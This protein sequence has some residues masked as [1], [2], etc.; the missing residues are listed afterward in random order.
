MGLNVLGL[1]ETPAR[2][3]S[4]EAEKD[5]T[6]MADINRAVYDDRHYLVGIALLNLGE[7][8]IQ[9]KDLRA[10]RA[11]RY[12]EALSRFIE[13][14]PAGP[15][16]HRDRASPAGARFGHGAEIQGR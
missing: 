3:T 5:F 16:Q 7:V 1:L 12:R 4:A 14:L 9:E 2:D 13:K 15:P 6:R 8:Y 10:R 11:F